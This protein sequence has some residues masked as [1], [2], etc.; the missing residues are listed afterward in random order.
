METWPSLAFDWTGQ[1]G[2]RL[3]HK[4][5]SLANKCNEHEFNIKFKREE[6]GVPSINLKDP[7]FKWRTNINKA[8]E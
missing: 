3:E 1:L 5:N 4:P 6:A 2:V 7:A 8:F